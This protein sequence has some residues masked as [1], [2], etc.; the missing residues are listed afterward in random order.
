MPTNSSFE[1]S[2]LLFLY[3]GAAKVTP[4]APK[5]ATKDPQASY[6]EPLFRSFLETSS[7]QA[8]NEAPMLP[9]MAATAP[10]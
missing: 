6:L 8:A 2:W 4:C 9:Q 3:Y 10:E 1:Y 7:P 5:G